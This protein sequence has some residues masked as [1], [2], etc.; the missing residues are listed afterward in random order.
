MRRAMRKA[1]PAA[2]PP[3]STVWSALLS[4]VVPAKLPL[5]QPKTASAVGNLGDAGGDD[6]RRRIHGARDS[7]RQRERHCETVG[8]ADDNVPDDRARGEVVLDV[9][10]QRHGASP[11]Y[12]PALSSSLLTSQK[13]PRAIN[14]TSA[15]SSQ[16][17][18]PS[19]SARVALS[20]EP[21]QTNAAIAV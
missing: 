20:R 2:R 6:E 15:A 9:R 1:A 13:V 18:S 4:G 5:T 10:C 21:L 16:N 8:H 12:R 3:M 7:R 11:A 14:T 19:S 17:G